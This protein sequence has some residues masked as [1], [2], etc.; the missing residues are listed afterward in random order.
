MKIMQ[1]FHKGSLHV[2]LVTP[3]GIFDVTA[4]EA[5]IPTALDLIKQEDAGKKA[6]NQLLEA[7]G[8]NHDYFHD[9]QDVVPAPAVT[10]SEKILCIGLNYAKHAKESGMEEPKEPIVFNKFANSLTADRQNVVIPP[11]SNKVDYEAELAIIIG[12]E[13]SHISTQ[14]ASD[15]IYGYAVSNDVS[16]RDLQFKSP[17][18]L[19]GKT[20]DGFCPLGTDVVLRDE[21][22]DP[23]NLEIKAYVNGE[24][25]QHSNTSDMI[26]N[27][28]EIV[29]YVSRF[30]T[31]KPGDLILTGTPEGVIM[32]YPKEKQEWLKTGDNVKIEIEQIGSV[33]NTFVKK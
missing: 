11:D 1:F 12:K 26:F 33:E 17:Q 14:E 24:V 22:D 25:R 3:D 31:L 5:S 10:G 21:I 6:I 4:A 15:Y 2:G 16:A 28:D 30:M 19:I 8:D 20:C 7:F 23:G 9:K 32:G 27:C 29:S 18:W 13:A